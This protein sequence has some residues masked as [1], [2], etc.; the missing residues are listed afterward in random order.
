MEKRLLPEKRRRC[1]REPWPGRLYVGLST[2]LFCA[3]EEFKRILGLILM[4]LTAKWSRQ[5]NSVSGK[6]LREVILFGSKSVVFELCP[7]KVDPISSF[8]F[9][10]A[11][12]RIPHIIHL[13][14]ANSM[15]VKCWG[16]GRAEVGFSETGWP[17]TN[18]GDWTSLYLTNRTLYV[19]NRNRTS[20]REH[21]VD[22]HRAVSFP[23]YVYSD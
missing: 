17:G 7:W 1:P 10:P 20:V 13:P 22:M 14:D 18:P 19:A 16:K 5:L 15:L 12:L 2:P 21:F 4:S 23:E 6:R 11:R 9:A 3:M 8:T